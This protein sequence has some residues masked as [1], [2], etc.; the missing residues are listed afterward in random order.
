[1]NPTNTPFDA[2]SA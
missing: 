2:E 1:M